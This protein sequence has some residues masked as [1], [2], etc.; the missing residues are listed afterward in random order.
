M[1]RIWIDRIDALAERRVARAAQRAALPPQPERLNANLWHHTRQPWVH[2]RYPGMMSRATGALDSIKQILADDPRTQRIVAE[3][4]PD[5]DL[6]QLLIMPELPTDITLAIREQ[7]AYYAQAGI[8]EQLQHLYKPAGYT[9]ESELVIP[10]SNSIA[11]GGS[12][13]F[14]GPPIIAPCIIRE[15]AY[16]RGYLWSPGYGL[17]HQRMTVEGYG[18]LLDW[19]AA[20]GDETP[21]FGNTARGI[22]RWIIGG[23]L[24]PMIQVEW[25]PAGVLTCESSPYIR[26]F[27]EPLIRL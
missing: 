10:V 7:V 24:V 2:A 16:S 23:S 1:A 22:D 27:A 6:E 21:V 3:R 19:Q 13:T 15:I 11:T 20:G 18:L 8:E 5:Y 25:N 26:I 4:F 12:H 17:N 9:V 14:R